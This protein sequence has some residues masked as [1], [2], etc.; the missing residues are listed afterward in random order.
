MQ[1]LIFLV[2]RILFNCSGG[3]QTSWLFSWLF[4]FTFLEANYSVHEF[5]VIFLSEIYLDS[6]VLLDDGNVV[7]PGYNLI[8]SDH[9]S[10]TKPRGFFLYC[11]NYLPLTVLNIGYLL[12]FVGNKPC[13]FLSFAISQVN[14][15]K[16]LIPSLL[17]LKWLCIRWHKKVLF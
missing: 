17:I 11:Q 13:I 5:D 6:P 2:F 15:R 8:R 10:N 14:S 16:G 4:K 9:L 3:L 1:R 7:I 12:N